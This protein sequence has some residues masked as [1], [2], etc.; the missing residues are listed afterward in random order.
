MGTAATDPAN[1][2]A[3]DR[4]GLTDGGNPEEIFELTATIGEGDA[5]MEATHVCTCR[6][7][8]NR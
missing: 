4:V 2:D 6:G 7:N 1:L 3:Y 5:A 8:D